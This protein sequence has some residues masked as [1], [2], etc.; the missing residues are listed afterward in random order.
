LLSLGIHGHQLAELRDLFL[1]LLLS[2]NLVPQIRVGGGGKAKIIVDVERPDVV[3]NLRYGI[4]MMIERALVTVWI[5]RNDS[6][7][8][9]VRLMR[10][11]DLK[12]LLQEEL[13][14]WIHI[15]LLVEQEHLNGI[16]LLCFRVGHHHWLSRRGSGHRRRRCIHHRSE[17]GLRDIA[18]HRNLRASI[19]AEHL[20]CQMRL[21]TQEEL[22]IVR[23]EFRPTRYTRKVPIL[24]NRGNIEGERCE[25][26]EI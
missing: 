21:L 22:V 18:G 5:R 23:S 16:T 13:Q 7:V 26:L 19:L 8:L 6:L 1:L 9:V 2:L 17:G 15:L 3:E 25:F 10:G 11:G 14:G 12:L 20:S 4:V 24:E